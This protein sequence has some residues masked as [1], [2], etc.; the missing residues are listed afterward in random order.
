M[1]K[2]FAILIIHDA[3]GWARER[4]RETGDDVVDSGGGVMNE[5]AVDDEF[6]KA[7]TDN[8]FLC[9]ASRHSL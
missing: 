5:S 4:E 3:C 6:L 1:N 8:Y 9:A 2:D 7:T